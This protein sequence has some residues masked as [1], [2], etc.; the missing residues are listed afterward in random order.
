MATNIELNPVESYFGVR[1]FHEYWAGFLILGILLVIIGILSI[2][3]GNIPVMGTPLFFGIIFLV[4]GVLQF[5]FAIMGRNGQGYSQTLIEATFYSIIGLILLTNL[6]LDKNPIGLLLLFATFLTVTG[7][8]K[9]FYSLATP[10][11]RWGWL[12][13]SGIVSIILGILFWVQ[14]ASPVEFLI[15]LFMGLDLIFIGWYWIMLSVSAKQIA[16]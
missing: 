9:F 6:D 4:A 12:L 5:I 11:V 2:I 8:F 14:L 7:V 1:R 10:L 16:A 13:L 3:G 15:G